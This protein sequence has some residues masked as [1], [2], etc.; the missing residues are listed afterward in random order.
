MFS[1]LCIGSWAV[2]LRHLPSL[3]GLAQ[4]LLLSP[5]AC[6]SDPNHTL[7]AACLL[8]LFLCSLVPSVIPW[9]CRRVLAKQLWISVDAT[10]SKQKCYFCSTAAPVWTNLLGCSRISL[11]F[12]AVPWVSQAKFFFFQS[13]I[14]IYSTAPHLIF[15][16]RVIPS[17]GSCAL[18]AAVLLKAGRLLGKNAK[19]LYQ[20]LQRVFQAKI[21]RTALCQIGIPALTAQVWAALNPQHWIF[22]VSSGALSCAVLSTWGCRTGIR[23]NHVRNLGYSCAGYSFQTAVELQN[24][25]AA[26]L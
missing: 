19:K 8:F 16:P 12:S 4:P 22:P 14:S 25:L 6:P 11:V 20:H 5:S 2:Q 21:P 10:T 1:K 15:Q 17:G 23:E 3:Q 13:G 24:I 7:T 26:H 18:G 9:L